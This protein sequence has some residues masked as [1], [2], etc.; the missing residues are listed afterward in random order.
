M[1]FMVLARAMA[2]LRAALRARPGVFAAAATATAAL[3]VLLPPAVLSLAR[4]PVDYATLN[5]W[6]R[7]LPDYLASDEHPPLVKAAKLWNLALFW[8]SADSP[9]GGT[10]W[11]FAVD[12]ADLARIA[13]VAALVGA[14]LALWR[15]A[16]ERGLVAPALRHGGRGGAL[17]AVLGVLGLSTGP[18]SVMGCGAPVLPVVALAFAGLS[19]GTLA[20]LAGLSR[21]GSAALIAALAVGVLWLGARVGALEATGRSAPPRRGAQAIT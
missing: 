4:K 2:G 12:T 10:E 20:A 17:G 6:L 16:R 5:P 1:V 9:M 14:Y 3:S 15:H 13:L 11:G 21:W 7:R 19:S 18:C 8:F